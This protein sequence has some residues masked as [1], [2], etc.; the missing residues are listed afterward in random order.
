MWSF[1]YYLKLL[2]SPFQQHIVPLQCILKVFL[3]NEQKV[4]IIFAY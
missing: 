1:E 3:K 4:L 2:L